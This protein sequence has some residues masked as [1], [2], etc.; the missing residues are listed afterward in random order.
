MNKASIQ[1]KNIG[2]ADRQNVREYEPKW[3]KRQSKMS[4]DVSTLHNSIATV[5]KDEGK[6]VFHK[7]SRSVAPNM[8]EIK[9][10]RAS[11]M[12]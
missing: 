8:K 11:K 6:S 2:I 7:K 5:H 3:T 12:F 1:K 9:I 10:Q 4:K